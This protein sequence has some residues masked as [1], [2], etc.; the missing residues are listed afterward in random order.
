MTIG[1]YL[2]S[3]ELRLTTHPS[4]MPM[5]WRTVFGPTR[6]PLTR[7]FVISDWRCLEI[8]LPGSPDFPK[9]E[10]AVLVR[11]TAESEEFKP[12]QDEIEEME[13][14]IETRLKR[15]SAGV[16]LEVED[17]PAMVAKVTEIARAA[18]KR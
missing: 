1:L 14:F 11:G 18:A 4:S 16:F 2:G 17:L 13:V 7:N 15:N 12:S 9:Q 8:L 6:V 3:P 10:K 5:K